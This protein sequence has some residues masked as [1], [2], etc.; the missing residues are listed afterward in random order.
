MIGGGTLPL[1]NP[2]MLIDSAMCSYAWSMLGFSSSG[3][4]AMRQ[5]DASGAEL[6]DGGLHDLVLLFS[7]RC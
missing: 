7:T 1:R 4:T 5:L 2:G 6:V 3:V